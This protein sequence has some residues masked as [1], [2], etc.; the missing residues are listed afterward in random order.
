ME[1]ASL[2][3]AEDVIAHIVCQAAEAVSR[4]PGESQSQQSDRAQAATRA[5]MSF[6]PCDAVE[7]MIASRCVMLHEVLVDS[8]NGFLSGEQAVTRS[9]IVAMDR[10]IGGNLVQFGRHHAEQYDH[11]SGDV[12]QPAAI[13]DEPDADATPFSEAFPT[14]PQ[15]AGF[16]RQTRRAFARQFRKRVSQAARA[17]T[18]AETVRPGLT[19]IHNEPTATACATTAS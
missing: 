4:R 13:A 5:I 6:Q 11:E 17:A 18:Q 14:A 16:N 2:H 15:V 10:A 9:N 7:A 3:E 1:A 19:S 8:V 12:P